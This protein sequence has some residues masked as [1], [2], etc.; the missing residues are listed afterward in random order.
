[1]NCIACNEPMAVLELE[2]VEIDHCLA[3]GGIWLDTGEL[4]IL[5][6]SGAQSTRLLN[7]LASEGDR[8][9]GKHKCPICLKR[10]EAV[11]VA[12][13]L[14]IQL[15]RCYANHGIWF[16]RGELRAVLKYLDQNEHCAAHRLL[17]N[18]FEK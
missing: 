14:P 5:T 8:C 17:R 7:Q 9:P 13:M 15:D 2:G 10:M 6:G 16:D 3:C 4:E 11:T 18:I 12:A 1:M